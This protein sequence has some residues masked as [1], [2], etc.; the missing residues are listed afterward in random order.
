MNN[1]L[2]NLNPILIGIIAALVFCAMVLV[3]RS[4]DILVLVPLFFGALPIY[5]A[6]LG[7]GAR[8]G[9]VAVVIVAAIAT[10]FISAEY[11]ENVTRAWT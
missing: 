9:V 5:V 3:F 11:T 8:A 10:F 1:N 6:A 2:T 7:W 4:I